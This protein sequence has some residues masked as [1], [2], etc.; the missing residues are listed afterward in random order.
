MQT[1]SAEDKVIK[2]PRRTAEKLH[3]AS[4][5]DV[6]SP[7]KKELGYKD[8]DP[9]AAFGMDDGKSK[10]EL[11]QGEGTT[12]LLKFFLFVACVGSSMFGMDQAL[13]SSVALFAPEALNLSS[14][15]WSW[16]SSGAT[17]GATFG[18]IAAVPL[19]W[20][21]GRKKVLMMSSLLYITGVVMATAAK[22]FIVLLL[23]R[24][25]MGVG[26]GTEAMT[27]P[28][29]ISE[30]VPKSHRGAHLN[31]F[32]SLYNLGVVF[33]D[34][35][36]AIFIHVHP[37]SWR[38]MIGSG[39]LGPILQ[40]G[41]VF[42]F[43]ESPRWLLKNGNKDDARRA[44]CRFR[45]PTSI[46]QQEYNEMVQRVEQEMY[47]T[48]SSWSV[49]KDILLNPRIRATFVIG[50]LVSLAQQWNGATALGYYE[51]TI[52]TELG[53]DTFEAVYVTVPIG[54]WMLLWTIP[55]Y[56]LLDKLGRRKTLLFTFP[57]F[58]I[59]LIISGTTIL[60]HS[61]K[62]KA[63]GF[64]VG[65]ALYYIGYEQGISP[66]AWA[67]NGE[68]YELHV[69]NIGMAWGAS[70]LLGSAFVSTYTFTRQVDAL[71]L[72]GVFGLYA[73]LSTVFWILL[74][75][76][77]PETGNVTLEGVRDRFEGGLMEIAKRNWKNIGLSRRDMDDTRMTLPGIQK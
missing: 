27:I 25:I 76:F 51:P 18:A 19:N 48:S 13:L 36:D 5:E 29:Y 56:F 23:G 34:V 33:G 77:L 63:I 75:F 3:H 47:E 60:Q 26:M 72:P 1:Y 50:L 40:F 73:A 6:Q 14:K 62:K 49:W 58:I 32:N 38:Y 70:T 55:P 16:I 28:I 24:V 12:P 69:R 64:F 30:V 59:G 44:W 71:S 66:L 21:V 7:S 2:S 4:Y 52:F 11:P 65:L 41:C 20:L 42:F 8:F 54:F 15:Q 10:D 35:V 39:A 46:S 37:G 68:I 57:I 53:L 45:R 67:L 74:F 17:L 31:I 43:P 61:P 9:K 22:D